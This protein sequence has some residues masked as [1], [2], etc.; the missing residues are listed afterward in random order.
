VRLAVRASYHSVVLTFYSQNVH[1][2]AAVKTHPE[3]V[4]CAVAVAATS[5][6]SS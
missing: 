5:E 4:R 6:M 2:L 1:G 3:G